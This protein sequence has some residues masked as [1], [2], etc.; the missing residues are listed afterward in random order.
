MPRENDINAPGF[1]PSRVQTPKKSDLTL[2]QESDFR[3]NF[4][5]ISN[6]DREPING[7]QRESNW[8]DRRE[9]RSKTDLQPRLEDGAD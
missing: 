3:S 5:S 9:K 2:D 4:E 1:E 7:G 6:V 8:R